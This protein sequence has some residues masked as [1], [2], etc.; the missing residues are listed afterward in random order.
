MNNDKKE[1][2]E[3]NYERIISKGNINCGISTT[4]TYTFCAICI[5]RNYAATQCIIEFENDFKVYQRH[6]KLEKLLS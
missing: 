5:Y 2:F 3:K 1:F 4:P 6:K